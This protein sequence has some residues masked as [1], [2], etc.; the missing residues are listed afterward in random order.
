MNKSTRLLEES[1]GHEFSDRALLQQALTHRSA[2]SHNN[3]RLEFLGDAILG[4]VI[5]ED[6]YSRYPQ[7]SEGELSRL[8][9]R[10]VRHESLTDIARALDIGQHLSLGGGERRSGG[11]QRDSILSDAVEAVLGAVY[12]DKGFDACKTCILVLFKDKLG[13][14]SEIEFL[15]DAK[16]R[17]QEYLQSRQLALPE[18]VVDG[19]TGF[20]VEPGDP[21]GLAAAIGTALADPDRLRLLGQAGRDWFDAQRPCEHRALLDLYQRAVMQHSVVHTLSPTTTTFPQD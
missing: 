16:T 2:G 19:E 1:L 11:H 21:T 10:L 14:L 13:S 9:S 7:A 18:Y 4:A 12:L 5:A 20:V 3:E 8:R 15:K 17:L 6:L